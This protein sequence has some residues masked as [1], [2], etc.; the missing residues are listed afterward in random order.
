MVRESKALK[1]G[2]EQLITMNRGYYDTETYKQ[3]VIDQCVL[4]SDYDDCSDITTSDKSN[5]KSN[6]QILLTY[7][8]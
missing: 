2:N 5:G 8:V 6:K 4:I 1:M 3:A 7:H